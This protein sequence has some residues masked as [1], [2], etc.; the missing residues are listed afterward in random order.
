VKKEIGIYNTDNLAV[1]DLGIVSAKRVAINSGLS[2][3]Q[4]SQ[5]P[6]ISAI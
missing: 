1:A 6:L 3:E 5:T 4:I 2:E